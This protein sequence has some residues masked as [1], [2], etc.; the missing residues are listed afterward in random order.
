MKKS[1]PVQKPVA[2]PK[3]PR[4]S[5][6]PSTSSDFTE[7][8]SLQEIKDLIEFVAEKEFDEIELE[9]GD[10]RLRLRKGGS[11][12]MAESPVH[13][14]MP[15]MQHVVAPPVVVPQTAQPP[16]AVPSSPVA[17]PIVEAAPAEENLH[18][19]TSPIVGTFYRA[20]SPTTEPFIKLGDLIEANQ[21]LCI[22]EAMKLMNEIQSDVSGTVIKVLVENGQ[23]VEYGQPLFGIKL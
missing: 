21:T 7:L 3:S 23:P 12:A 8:R 18:I 4:K 17:T 2:K 14:A 20:S 1:N 15:T 16:V 9:R 10:F 13:L 6:H 22:I 11:P 5:S 19:I